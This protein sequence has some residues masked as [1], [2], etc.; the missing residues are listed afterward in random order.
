ML[1][2]ERG[3]TFIQVLLVTPLALWFFLCAV[4]SLEVFTTKNVTNRAAREAQRFLSVYHDQATAKQV[5]VSHIAAFLPPGTW[6]APGG[7][8]GSI[9]QAFDPNN[10]NDSD[11]R[12]DVYFVDDGS[13]ACE[14]NVRYHIVALA[15]GMAKLFDPNAPLLGSYITIG[16]VDRGHR[17]FEP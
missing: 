15:P 1:N 11:G 9:R 5:A 6:S 8:G 3:F 2:N 7:G 12:P 16:S 14:A 10:P 4:T 17:E 13:A